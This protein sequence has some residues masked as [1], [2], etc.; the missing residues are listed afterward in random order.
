MDAIVSPYREVLKNPM[1]LWVG[2][3]IESTIRPSLTNNIALP[4]FSCGRCIASVIPGTRGRMFLMPRCV[5]SM[6]RMSCS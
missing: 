4:Y 2:R 3:V 1:L 5:S 6:R